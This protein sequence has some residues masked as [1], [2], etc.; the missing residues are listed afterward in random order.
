MYQPR[1][2][3]PKITPAFKKRILKDWQACFPN[4]VPDNSVS[5]SRRVGPLLVFVGFNISRGREDYEPVSG[6]HNL[7]NTRDFLTST[8]NTP[9][10]TIRT[11]AQDWLTVRAHE[12][13]QYIEAAERMKQQAPLPLEGP[14]SLN[15][16]IEAYMKY[17]EK[18]GSTTINLLQDPALIAAWAGQRKVAEKALDWRYKDF[19]TWPEKS[20]EKRGGLE[21]WYKDM[22]EKIAHPERLRAIVEEQVVFH[23]LEHI[24]VEELVID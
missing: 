19:A 17:V 22:K 16:I 6:V 2:P 10:R 13:G 5:L 11:N 1:F 15:M 12:E 23:K 20:H 7:C 14:I 24:P 18:R 4:L 8:L 21:G 3:K 9:L